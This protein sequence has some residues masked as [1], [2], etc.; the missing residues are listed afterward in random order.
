MY[1]GD[2]IVVWPWESCNEGEVGSRG[3]GEGYPTSR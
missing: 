1:W 3:E 2:E